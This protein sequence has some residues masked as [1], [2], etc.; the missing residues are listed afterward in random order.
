MLRRRILASAMASVMALTSVAV[1]ASAD[2]T[3]VDVKNVKTKADLE[4]YVKELEK[5]KTDGIYDY[6]TNS[7]T[8]FIN[9]YTYAENVLA[10]ATATVDDY[11]VAYSMLKNVVDGL[12]IYTADQL[13]TLI[14]SC[15]KIYETDNANGDDAIY[16]DDRDDDQN[17]SNFAAAYE[18]AQDYVG[19]GD[20]SMI[21]DAYEALDAAKKNLHALA[22]VTKA[23]FRSALKSYETLIGKEDANEFWRRGSFS[24]GWV[25]LASGNYW[26]ITSGN[27][28]GEFDTYGELFNLIKYGSGKVQAGWW[29]NDPT[30][31]DTDATL[32]AGADGYHWDGCVE[33]FINAQYDALT[34]LEGTTKTT[35]P[36]I[37][38]AYNAALDAV[39]L[40]NDW[41][42]DS[43]TRGTETSVKTLLK[44][45]HNQLV[46]AYKT[47]TA[48][49]VYEAVNGKKAGN[50]ITKNSKGQIT[51]AAMKNETKVAFKGTVDGADY[52]IKKGADILKEITVSYKDVSEDDAALALGLEIAE[53]YLAKGDVDEL[54]NL[55]A[56][57]DSTD[58]ITKPTGKSSQ[59]W[60]LVYRWLKYALEDKFP[61]ADAT[62][63]KSDV[64]ALISS[65][66]DL[67]DATGDAAVFAAEHDDLVKA[68][69]SAQA[70]VAAA[71]KDKSY[72]DGN[73]VDGATSTDVY[74]TLNGVYK[75][76]NE[77]L[78]KYKYSYGE[79]YNKI[80]EVADMIDAGD[81]K[82]ADDLVKAVNDL[83]YK[84]TTTANFKDE[85]N[86]IFDDERNFVDYN[87]LFTDKDNATDEEK[88]L[89]A[90]YDA[91]VAAVKAQTEV[92]VALG[93]VDGNGTVNALD[94]AAILKAV[95]D[96]TAIDAKVGDVD[97]N[98]TVNA[99]DAAKILADVV[100]G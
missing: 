72:K 49:N 32:V 69:Q 23:Q 70:W 91:V 48:E 41:S 30:I 31:I 46:A 97:G 92:T 24:K 14:A 76:L 20:S 80:A 44:T 87:R 9:A 82:P 75:T 36:T 51:G 61:A 42:V 95:V 78:A 21:T 45:Y 17:F 90:A 25:N 62:Y 28:D 55:I 37:V 67:A 47:T 94:A 59:E 73:E 63:K 83:A 52:D 99:L 39:A 12:T 1:V 65:A 13:K 79:I 38:K 15:K 18:T 58:S 54:A 64:V 29:A 5:V 98:G 53:K 26:V 86:V 57:I 22:S 35:N 7:Q 100:A 3:A 81:L 43:V 8:N 4:A 10:D 50:W 88:A 84:F 85:E 96:G 6:G 77:K 56:L 89:L 2:E 16:E 27:F 40:F 34:Q 66:Y 60:T 71:N 19:S 68:R 74:N 11:T 33:D 93:D